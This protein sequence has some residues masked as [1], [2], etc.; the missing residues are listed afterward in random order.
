MN[1][2]KMGLFFLREMTEAALIF[3]SLF[4]NLIK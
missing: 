1:L 3:F 4:R 2:N